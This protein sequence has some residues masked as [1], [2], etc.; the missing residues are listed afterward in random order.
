MC[1]LYFAVYAISLCVCVSLYTTKGTDV[2]LNK[3]LSLFDFNA[4]YL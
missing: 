4:A 2:T 1:L 3:K